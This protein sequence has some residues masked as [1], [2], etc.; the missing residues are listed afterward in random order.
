[1]ILI[2][3]VGK[4]DKALIKIFINQVVAKIIKIKIF[5][6]L[7]NQVGKMDKALIKIFINRV[8]AKIIKIKIF[9]ILINQ[10]ENA[11]IIKI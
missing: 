7:I 5:L 1:M 8:V 6:I 4:M 9:L 11:I 3:Q 2:N 10:A